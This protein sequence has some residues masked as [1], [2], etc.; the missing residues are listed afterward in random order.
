MIEEKID[1]NIIWFKIIF[2][3]VHLLLVASFFGLNYNK[4]Y[5]NI[6]NIGTQVFIALYLI[7]RFQPYRTHTL[8]KNDYIIFLGAGSVILLNLLLTELSTS[9]FFSNIPIIGKNLFN[10]NM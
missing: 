6:I 5:Y 2:V 9:R 1:K 8:Y 10:S 3:S 4:F 7:Y